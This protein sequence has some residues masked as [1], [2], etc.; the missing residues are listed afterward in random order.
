VTVP[1]RH[2]RPP[3]L[4]TRSGEVTVR[5]VLINTRSYYHCPQ[6]SFNSHLLNTHHYQLTDAS[7]TEAHSISLQSAYPLC[8]R[9][10]SAV[11]P[12]NGANASW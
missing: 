12:A 4:N 2:P 3:A 6:G 8:L 9:R 11:R 1:A 7:Y 10:S 5:Q